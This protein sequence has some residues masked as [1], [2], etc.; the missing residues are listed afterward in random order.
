[1]AS[2]S[3]SQIVSGEVESAKKSYEKSTRIAAEARAIVEA[4]E[5]AWKD[6]CDC[7]V[8]IELNLK[9][10][11]ALDRYKAAQA[12]AEKGLIAA[13][14]LKKIGEEYKVLSRLIQPY[15]HK[16]DL[17]ARVWMRC[18][19]GFMDTYG[20]DV[21]YEETVILAAV[22]VAAEAVGNV[23]VAEAAVDA[24]RISADATVDAT[25]AAAAAAS[26]VA[27]I[28]ATTDETEIFKWVRYEDPSSIA[29]KAAL[30]YYHTVTDALFIAVEKILDTA[31]ATA[32][33][34]TATDAAACESYEAAIAVVRRQFKSH[35]DDIQ[36]K[37]TAATTTLQ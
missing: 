14:E 16:Q 29:T 17:T 24:T 28:F 21:R 8:F 27:A 33:D 20:A 35:L 22:A 15:K 36:R 30:K 10:H 1:M 6:A 7:P 26:D 5:K 31:D 11:K 12:E 34:A 37:Q 4:A 2:P 32:T 18:S 25:L 3:F 23:R 13:E 9:F 19:A